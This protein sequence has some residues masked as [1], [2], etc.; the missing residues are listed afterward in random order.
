MYW[1]LLIGM[2][3]RF[4]FILFTNI[5]L[6]PLVLEVTIVRGVF[7]LPQIIHQKQNRHTYVMQAIKQLKVN[8]FD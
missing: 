7:C 4:R 5:L 1:K 8:R 2:S 6:T 3:F